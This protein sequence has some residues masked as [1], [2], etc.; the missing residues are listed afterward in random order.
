MHIHAALLL[1][2][3]CAVQLCSIYRQTLYTVVRVNNK[4][5]LSLLHFVL[6]PSQ[7]LLSLS[8]FLFLSISLSASLSQ[9]TILM[10]ICLMLCPFIFHR[11]I[12]F[13]FLL[14]C[15]SLSFSLLSKS[16]SVYRPIL[17][18]IFVSAFFSISSLSLF[19]VPPLKSNVHP[20]CQ[21]VNLVSSSF[22]VL[23]FSLLVCPSF[24]FS[25]IPF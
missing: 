11:P 24:C 25:P 9:S 2:S 15:M 21:S 22:S 16:V 5:P 19:S 10:Y 1:P 23:P 4:I 8:V 14:H 20:V 7:C 17:L 18:L 13:S 6:P 12:S 3:L